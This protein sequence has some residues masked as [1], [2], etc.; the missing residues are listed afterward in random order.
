MSYE[1]QPRQSSQRLVAYRAEKEIEF[2]RE[3][4]AGFPKTLGIERGD[5]ASDL[6]Q[7][8]LEK[9]IKLGVLPLQTESKT[10]DTPLPRPT[11][12]KCLRHRNSNMP[13]KFH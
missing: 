1:K 3:A 6:R 8:C 9:L 10:L 7:Y 11:F 4:R 2:L 5:A 12:R 13:R